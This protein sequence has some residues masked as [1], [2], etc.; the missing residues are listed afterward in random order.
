MSI[1]AGTYK[2]RA[3]GQ[4]VLGES[5]Q[6]KTPFVEVY[7]RITEGDHEGKEARWTSYFSDTR[8]ATA[9]KSPAERTLEALYLCG[10]QTEDGDVSVFSDGELH[11]LDS[12]EVEVVVELEEYEKEGETRTSPRVQWVNRL[13]GARYLNVKNAMSKTS[14]QSFG[15]RM[16]G[17]ALKMKAKTATPEPDVSFPHGA[18]EPKVAAGGARKGW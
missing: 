8:S 7:F 6:K 3:V 13:G 9:K 5:A 10:W 4:V 17:L 12:H 11:G 18:N 14:A 15:E 2:A 1:T 16:K